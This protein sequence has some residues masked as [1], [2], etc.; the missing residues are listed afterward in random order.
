MISITGSELTM[1]KAYSQ[2]GTIDGVCT[3]QM[4]DSH[5]T[6]ETNI[7]VIYDTVYK[8]DLPHRYANATFA[9][10]CFCFLITSVDVSNHT[11]ARIGC[12]HS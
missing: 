8:L 2:T 4:A 11:H 1:S 12:Q 6:T 5:T 10:K 3:G 7:K 9:G